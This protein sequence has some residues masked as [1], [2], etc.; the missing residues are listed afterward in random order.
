MGCLVSKQIVG[1]AF[2]VVAEFEPAA[3]SASV[4]RGWGMMDRC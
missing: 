2:D 4:Q 1:Q 3:K